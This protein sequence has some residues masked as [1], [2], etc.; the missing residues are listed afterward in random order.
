VLLDDTRELLIVADDAPAEI[1][2]VPDGVF[3]VVPVPDRYDIR[4]LLK[5][6]SIVAGVEFATFNADTV[7]D[8]LV[9]RISQKLF[10]SEFTP[11]VEPIN[12]PVDS[13]LAH[14]V[15]DA[16]NTSCPP[17]ANVTEVLVL[18]RP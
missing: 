5:I 9:P 7:L 8:V 2:T 3:D 17:E 13:P 10:V 4:P 18:D 15:P 6:S 11:V 16:V 1:S 14:W 12:K